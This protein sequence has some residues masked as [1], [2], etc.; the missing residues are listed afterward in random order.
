MVLNPS[1]SDLGALSNGVMVAR[2]ADRLNGLSCGLKQAPCGETILRVL[3]EG[4]RLLQAATQAVKP[5]CQSGNHDTIR[6]RTQI[7][8]GWIEHH[9]LAA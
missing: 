3:F 1:R 2:L 4:W 5:V 8:S 9:L 7:A 6:Q